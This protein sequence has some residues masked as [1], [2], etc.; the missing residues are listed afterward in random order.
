MG[1]CL[2]V[3][4]RVL[5]GCFL[6]F[7]RPKKAKKHS[8]S[9]L[10]GTPRQLPKIA[11]KALRGALQ[12]R[13]PQHSCKWRPGSQAFKD[14]LPSSGAHPSREK[15]STPLFSEAVP[16][17][18]SQNCLQWGRS[19]L[20]DPAGSPKIRFLNRDSGNILSIFPGKTATHRV[21]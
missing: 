3:P 5:F 9:T 13:A 1:N 14:T 8:K 20:F 12:A 4:Q 7:F 10:W 19:N 11:Q 6:A 18:N 2:R 16:E 15:V 17:R 21:H